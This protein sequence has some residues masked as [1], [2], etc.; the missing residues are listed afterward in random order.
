VESEKQRN[1]EPKQNDI[2]ITI[3]APKH[4]VA[5]SIPFCFG[6][7]LPTTIQS[8]RNACAPIVICIIIY[9]YSH[10]RHGIVYTTM[11]FYLY[12][13]NNIIYKIDTIYIYIYQRQL[14]S[15][16]R[17]QPFSPLATRAHDPP[18][19][20][21]AA[22]A[23]GGSWIARTHTCAPSEGNGWSCPTMITH[24][25]YIFVPI[26]CLFFFYPHH[27]NIV[28]KVHKILSL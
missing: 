1:D 4:L 21:A 20:R 3:Q 15:I 18:I 28:P 9:V 24:L 13:I 25:I 6:C 16:C 12:D 17:Q 7:V 23:I 19:A 26:L 10:L 8:W 14:G 5:N 22:R 27:A 11:H 2:Q